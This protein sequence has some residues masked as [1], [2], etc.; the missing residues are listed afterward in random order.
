M[1]GGGREM[2]PVLVMLF[3]GCL[4][5]FMLPA[6]VDWCQPLPLG[7]SETRRVLLRSHAKRRQ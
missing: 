2:L 5:L 4:M 7:V 1:L 3:D 6:A